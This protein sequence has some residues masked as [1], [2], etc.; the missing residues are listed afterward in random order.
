MSEPN[1]YKDAGPPTGA[2]E[3]QFQSAHVNPSI[4]TYEEVNPPQYTSYNQT[5]RHEHIEVRPDPP[6]E[7]TR[8]VVVVERQVPVYFGYEDPYPVTSKSTAIIIL[9]VN[10]FL[11]GIGTMIIGCLDGVKHPWF[12]ILNGLFQLITAWFIIGWIMAIWSSALLLMKA[13]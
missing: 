13:E 3:P 6:I 12:F 10:I 5:Y 4:P 1:R 11:P 2:P 9:L 7:R 8:E